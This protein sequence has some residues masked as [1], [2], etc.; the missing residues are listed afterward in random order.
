MRARAHM[1]IPISAHMPTCV[2]ARTHTS[3]PNQSLRMEEGASNRHM[4]HRWTPAT[5]TNGH[6]I[7]VAAQGANIV[8]CALDPPQGVCIARIHPANCSAVRCAAE[9]WPSCVAPGGIASPSAHSPATDPPEPS[10]ADARMLSPMPNEHTR[11]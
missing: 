11:E 4:G 3:S 10:S 2:Y 6:K 5:T 9:K 1:H 7:A 8:P